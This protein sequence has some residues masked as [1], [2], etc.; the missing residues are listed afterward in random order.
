MSCCVFRDPAM[1]DIFQEL[2]LIQSYDPKPRGFYAKRYKELL[3]QLK[4]KI[5]ICVPTLV[6]IGASQPANPFVIYS[7]QKMI[8]II[9]L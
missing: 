5:E 1:L 4:A 3:G 6:E 2:C 8:P 7:E 9:Q